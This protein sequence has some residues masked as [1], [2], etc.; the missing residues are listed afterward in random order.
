MTEDNL[1]E[2][3]TRNIPMKNFAVVEGI[4]YNLENAEDKQ[5][6]ENYVNKQEY[7]AKYG[8]RKSR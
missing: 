2:K 4:L 7:F 3:A 1:L 5:L 8:K 6:F